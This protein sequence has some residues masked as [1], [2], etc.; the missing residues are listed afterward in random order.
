MRHRPPLPPWRHLQPPRRRRTSRRGPLNPSRWQVQTWTLRYV[1]LSTLC[2]GARGCC[3]EVKFDGLL[4][5]ARCIPLQCVPT[6]SPYAG[7]DAVASL[8]RTTSTA[9]DSA[10]SDT[11]DTPLMTGVASGGSSPRRRWAANSCC[12]CFCKSS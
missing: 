2:Q 10:A 9:S 3:I 11:S 6:S 8:Q 12:G 7:A 4:V 5:L 1:C